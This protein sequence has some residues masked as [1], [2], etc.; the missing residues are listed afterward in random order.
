MAIRLRLIPDHG[1]VALCAARS[2]E[3]E[4]DVYLDDAQHY[5]LANKFARDYNEM[6][7][8]GLPGVYKDDEIVLRDESNNPAREWWDSVY[9]PGGS[10]EREWTEFLQAAEWQPACEGSRS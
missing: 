4:G 8:V 6:F 1:W 10:D 7:D 2:V 5:A 9:G 3:Q